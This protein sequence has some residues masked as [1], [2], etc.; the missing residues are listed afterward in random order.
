M[1]RDI[2]FSIDV[3]PDASDVD[4]EAAF[5]AEVS[6]LN[7]ALGLREVSRSVDAIGVM[8]VKLKRIP[9]EH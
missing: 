1:R 3:P 2:N 4:L 8:C 6:K 7:E 9:E 5:D